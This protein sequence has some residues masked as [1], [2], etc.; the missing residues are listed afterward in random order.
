MPKLNAKKFFSKRYLI[1]WLVVAGVVILAGAAL[2]WW[3]RVQVQPERVFQGML[4]QSLQTS[5]VTMQALQDNNGSEVDYTLQYSLGVEPKAHSIVKINQPGVRVVTETIGTQDADFTRY[6][7]IETD[8]ADE[9]GQPLDTSSIEGVWARD[10]NSQQ[11]LV[12]QAMLGLSLPLGA[13]PVPG[14]ELGP[15]VRQELLAQIANDGVYDVDY[16]SVERSREDGRLRYTYNVSMQVILYASMMKT[17][18]AQ[19]GLD[20][21]D[22]LDPN[23]YSGSPPLELQMTVDVRS[24][25]LVE[26]RLP[27]Q[28]EGEPEYVQTFSGHGIPVDVAAPDEY[29]TNAELQQLLQELKH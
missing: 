28:A 15:E 1:H 18:A 6:L 11:S 26:V 10:D 19:A 17:F 5:G 16:S 14:A 4:E 7:D 25:N 22:D 24:R 21:F 3:F 8:Q 12:G 9:D 13:M 27:G 29:I 2:L 23:Q 20:E